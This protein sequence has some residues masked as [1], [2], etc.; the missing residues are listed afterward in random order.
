MIYTFYTA[1]GVRLK[2]DDDACLDI[3]SDT[4]YHVLCEAYYRGTDIQWWVTGLGRQLAA[5]MAQ[6]EAEHESYEALTRAQEA[7]SKTPPPCVK[8]RRK[9]RYEPP[10]P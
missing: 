9:R 10:V 3:L 2:S 4:T 1:E 6:L 5:Y 8:V 7:G